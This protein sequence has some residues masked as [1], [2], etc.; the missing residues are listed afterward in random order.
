MNRILDICI[1]LTSERDRE[2]LLSRIL[3]TAMELAAC[4]AGT[5][6]LLEENCL[7][8]CRMV[9]RSLG[10]R[11]GGNDDPITLP[12]VPLEEV[13]VCSYAALHN[14]TIRIDDI[15]KNDQFDFTGSLE[16]DAMTGYQTS[17]ML[18]VPMT[19][20]KGELIGVSSVRTL[21]SLSVR[22]PPRQRSVSRISSI[23]TRSQIF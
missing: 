13:F 11:Q 23:L 10:I 21:K 19:N 12:S 9:T 18:V 3:D 22:L 6:Y 1:A 17:S 4:D 5:L 14:E 7:S 8:F 2:K 20:D 16:Y 15:R